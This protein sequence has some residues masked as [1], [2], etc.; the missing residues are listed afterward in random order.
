MNDRVWPFVFVVLA[1]YS[2]ALIGTEASTSHDFV[3]QF[4]ADIEGDVPFY[5]INTTLSVSLQWAAAL[6]FLVSATALGD[7]SEDRERRRFYWAQAAILAYTG[8][9][10]QFL[11]HEKLTWRL[12][13]GDHWVLVAVA[14]A[15]AALLATLGRRVLPAPA[16]T[17]LRAAVVLF[18]V[19]MTID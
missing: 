7:G 14:G 1:L 3:R 18:V 11:V 16:W 8:F 12:G 13:I 5:A 6:V 19:M 9:D 17:Q 10:D 4:F 15:E 2:V